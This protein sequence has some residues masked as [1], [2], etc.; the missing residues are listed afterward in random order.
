M[1]PRNVLAAI[2]R[3][4][5]WT[6][7]LAVF[8]ICTVLATQILFQPNI[9]ADY[10]LA[11]TISAF[12]EYLEEVLL[13][14]FSTLFL[15]ALIDA[16]LPRE[17]TARNAAL[18][19]AIVAGVAWGLAAGTLLRYGWGPYPNALFLAGEAIRW[20][21][22]AGVLTLIH[23]ARR[24]GEAAGR[25]LHELEVERIALEKRRLEARMQM[26]QALIEPHFLFNTLATVKRLYRTDLAGGTRMLDSLIQYLQGALPRLREDDSTLG[27]EI[28]LIGA[29]LEILR[30][31][32]GAR[33]RYELRVAP[34][35]RALPFPSM[36]LITLVENSIK[37]GIAPSTEGGSIEVRAG[38][39]QRRLEVEVADTG[40]GFK[41]ASGSGIG[42]ANIR[43]RLAAIFGE[44][45]QLTLLAN[46][47]CGVVARIV[48]PLPV[49][50]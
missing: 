4:L 31:R 37:H 10:E 32:M 25:A 23:E 43:A 28:E 33:L 1:T 34:E 38:V 47:P 7:V 13:V 14:G 16:L 22:L 29:Y 24:R 46:E 19:A 3:D 36:M 18:V 20:L 40:V 15:V 27:D 42:L 9:L 6:R 17:G 12:L 48:A 35:A 8:L 41:A 30:I 39:S 50:T 45:A 11:D 5:T 44:G 2:R 21:I 49:G 26:M